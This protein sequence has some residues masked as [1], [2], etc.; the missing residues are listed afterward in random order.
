MLEQV[1][2][3][4]EHVVKMT[5]LVVGASEQAGSIVYASA[6]VLASPGRGSRVQSAVLASAAR[7]CAWA[8][9]FS[10]LGACTEVQTQ[11]GEGKS[12]A[13]PSGCTQT[14][15]SEPDDATS[16]DVTVD[17]TSSED[18]VT[19]DEEVD[20]TAPSSN[21]NDGPDG[22]IGDPTGE[23]TDEATDEPTDVAEAGAGTTDEPT[24]NPIDA[25]EPNDASQPPQGDDADTDASV[26][27]CASFCG[28]ITELDSEGNE[29]VE[30]GTEVDYGH[31]PPASGPHYPIWAQYGAYDEV[32]PR[33]YWVHNL[34][35]GTVVL[36]YGPSATPEQQAEL[37]AVYDALPNDADCGHKRAILTEDPDLDDAI[38]VVAWTWV[39]EA[40]CVDANAI[41]G[42]VEEHRGHGTEAVCGDGSFTP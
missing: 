33:S 4:V 32:V 40:S 13:S 20:D 19:G 29:H 25:G 18:D 30:I 39:L 14:M 23:T 16:D 8:A 24:S 38:A 41:L 17:D 36:L 10:L 2:P 42:F 37:R 28:T 22:A 15:P 12:D 7:F 1:A 27:G 31:N 3:T 21:P 5:E 6:M 34:E 35:H 9:L 11:D 26:P